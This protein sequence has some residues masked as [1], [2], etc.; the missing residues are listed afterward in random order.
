MGTSS[1]LK[2]RDFTGEIFRYR[3]AGRWIIMHGSEYRKRF[4]CADREEARL[5]FQA[6]A[7]QRP[8]IYTTRRETRY[9]YGRQAWIRDE[10]YVRCGH[11]ASMQ[12]S[13]Y[14]RLHEGEIA[15]PI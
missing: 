12:C 2:I 11:P 9:D 6:M 5:T 7:A 14:G 10:R 3:L 8:P 1:T 13:C 15:E 4:P